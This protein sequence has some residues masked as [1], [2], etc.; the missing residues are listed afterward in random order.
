MTVQLK[1]VVLLA[2]YTSRSQAYLQAAEN[3]GFKFDTIILL[4][5]PKG[6]LPGQTD[7]NIGS[8]VVSEL[9]L[10]DL[11]V[12]LD[13]TVGSMAFSVTRIGSDSVN[14]Q[15]VVASL[16]NIN[17]KF[18]IYSG[19]GGQIVKSNVLDIAP[20]VHLHSGWL[21]D[22]RGSTTMYYSWINEGYIGVSAITLS[23]KIDQG[24]ILLRK[25]FSLPAK[26]INPDHIYDAAVRADT[27]VSLLRTYCQRGSLPSRVTQEQDR[28]QEY[29]VI[30]P[31][32]KHIALL[33]QESF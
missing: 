33:N 26:G 9:F 12:N 3:A 25:K 15:E 8:E 2:A 17:P 21:P 13:E 1:G 4:G 23:E 31:L 24:D 11:S 32:L 16:V 22:Y 5:D 6:N 28:A 29:Y 14:D 27:L 10:P 18:I 30:H 19:Y 7:S 20:L